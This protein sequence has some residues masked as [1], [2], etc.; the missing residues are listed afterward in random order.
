M[1]P[2]N[3]E[4]Y[5]KNPSKKLVTREGKEVRI[6]CTDRKGDCPIVAL[7]KKSDGNSEVVAAYSKDGVTNEYARALYDLFFVTEKKEGWINIWD[8]D[9]GTRCVGAEIY[10]SYEE[11]KNRNIIDRIA[12]VK[13]EWEE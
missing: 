5:L 11:A 13:I 12:T 8:C 3:L 6:L 7:I 9:D 1:K 2:F 4:E 10:D